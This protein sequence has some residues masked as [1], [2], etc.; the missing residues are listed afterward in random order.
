MYIQSYDVN[1][2][3]DMTFVLLVVGLGCQVVALALVD[4]TQV[5]PLPP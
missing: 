1:D 2:I 5:P 4:D 3:A